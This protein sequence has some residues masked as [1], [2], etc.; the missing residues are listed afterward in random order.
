MALP[1]WVDGDHRSRQGHAV[2]LKVDAH[3]K[4]RGWT[5]P[6]RKGMDAI[7]EEVIKSDPS[8]KAYKLPT[9][10]WAYYQAKPLLP[11]L[12]TKEDEWGARLA[13]WGMPSEASRALLDRLIKI[14][15]VKLPSLGVAYIDLMFDKVTRVRRLQAAH[16]KKIAW[17][18]RAADRLENP[19]PY[20]PIRPW[21]HASNRNIELIRAALRDGLSSVSKNCCSHGNQTADG[22]RP[23]GF[24]GEHRRRGAQETWSLR[25]AAER[26]RRLCATRQSS[27]KMPGDW[28]RQPRR[29]P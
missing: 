4:A 13:Q 24:H 3:L 26:R 11:P 1:K 27:F 25:P 9:L 15:T 7:L 14:V 5:R 19:R 18:E 29:N 17:L 12:Y 28:A 21:D 23:P 20:F 6:R 2:V 16:Q 8:F 22:S 10:R